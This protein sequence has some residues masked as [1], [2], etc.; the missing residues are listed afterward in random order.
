V[1]RP[2]SEAWDSGSAYERYAGRW[3]RVVAVEFLR[4]LAPRPG[5]A[6]ADVGCGTGALAS[7]VLAKTEPSSVVGI[8]SSEGFVTTARQGVGDPRARFDTGDATHLP[9]ATV[10]LDVTV[11][12]LVLN[13]VADHDAMAR[14]MVRVTKPGGC[15]AAYVWDY[16]GGMQ[17]MRHFWDAATAISPHDVKL[18]QAERFPL[19]QPGALQALFERTGLESVTVRAVEIPTVFESFDD[20]WQPFLGRTGAAPTYLASAPDEIREQIQL[21]LRARLAP[22]PDAPIAL[23]ARAW[24]VRGVVDSG[25]PLTT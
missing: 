19:C 4:W 10:S 18:D 21:H 11:S 14:E 24:A 8:D 17:M 6:W 3:S 15:V 23:T 16:A 9:W 7:T 12:G 22:T 25:R 20:Y 5:L 2:S 13:F 1:S